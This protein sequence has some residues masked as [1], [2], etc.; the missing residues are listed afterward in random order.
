MVDGPGDSGRQGPWFT[1]RWLVVV[2][3]LWLGLVGFFSM[4]AGMAAD[5]CTDATCDSG[6]AKAWLV[7]LAAQAGVFAAG[8][9]IRSRLGPR[10][11]LGVMA[12]LA[13]ASPLT[14]VAFASYVNRFF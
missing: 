5:G 4:L 6:V 7:L 12:G 8:I 10:A 13:V 11:R 3:W 2:L 14:V 1:G 9:L